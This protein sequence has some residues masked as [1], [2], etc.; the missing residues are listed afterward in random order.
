MRA[1]SSS[2]DG[3][4]LLLDEIDTCSSSLQVKLLRV[5][6]EGSYERVGDTQTMKSDVR[7][8]AATNQNLE[9]LVRRNAFRG[10]LYWRLNVISIQLPPLRER[11]GDIALLID[12][13]LEKYNG[14]RERSGKPPVLHVAPE[15]REAIL[16][17][18][19]A[20]QYSRTGEYH[21]AGV[22][23]GA[24]RY[25]ALWGSAGLVA[26]AEGRS[27]SGCERLQ[28]ELKRSLA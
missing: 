14:M 22:Y 1:G 2:A 8:I 12:H 15:A 18:P 28:C 3:G 26:A 23:L 6:E 24:R 19:S 17:Y 27:R 4:T 25:A 21:R 10:D 7:V 20:R 9:E 11:T 5:L 13:F 16:R